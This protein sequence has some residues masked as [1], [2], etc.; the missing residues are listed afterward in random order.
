MS[1]GIKNTKERILDVSEELFS[2]KGFDST[3]IDEIARRVGITK[4][5][6]YYHFRN[7]EE[8][9]NT[10]IHRY[11]AEG[12]A[13][14]KKL[15]EKYFSDPQRNF[16]DMAREIM[17]FSAERPRIAKIILME[18]IKDAERVPIFELYEQR[19]LLSAEWFKDKLKNIAVDLESGV[20]LEAFFMFFM[21][22]VS[23]TV[24]EERWCGHYGMD[25]EKVRE[26]FL[27][28]VTEYYENIMKPKMIREQ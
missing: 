21:P 27:S 5:V 1:K 4:S 20:M 8:I 24:F 25:V 13:F 15:A 9:L 3:G 2:E 16:L 28:I 22:W 7:K 14:K 11:F 18:S 17:R 19:A 12:M 26:K 10:L 23:Y 6:I